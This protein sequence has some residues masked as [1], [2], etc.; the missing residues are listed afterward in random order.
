MRLTKAEKQTLELARKAV[1][2]AKNGD[3]IKDCID[4]SEIIDAIELLVKLSECIK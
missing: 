4:D 2:Y 1:E 3:P